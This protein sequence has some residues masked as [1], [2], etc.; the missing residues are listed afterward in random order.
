MENL[1]IG[2]MINPTIGARYDNYREQDFDAADIYKNGQYAVAYTFPEL[3][4]ARLQYIGGFRNQMYVFNDPDSPFFDPEQDDYFVP[5]PIPLPLVAA[6][7]AY[8]GNPLS[9][10][11]AFAYNRIENLTIDAGFTY[12]LRLSDDFVTTR[13]PV[14]ISAAAIYRDSRWS[15]AGRMDFG[16]P[17]WTQVVQS[18]YIQ[19]VID[20]GFTLNFNFTAGYNL[21][22]ATVGT[23][24]AMKYGA[25]NKGIRRYP[26]LILNPDPDPDSESD[27]IYIYDV[28][29]VPESDTS[30]LVLGAGAWIMKQIGNASIKIGLA[31]SFPT[32]NYNEK[33]YDL[34]KLETY[35]I[36]RYAKGP[37]VF[38]I[39]I[40]FGYWL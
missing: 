14:K 23:E 10:Q 7:I 28:I 31:V 33:A 2:T 6:N 36:D 35:D 16:F 1:F 37:W 18:E 29:E 9:F 27:A 40:V 38:T 22:F 3:G 34:T 32:R 11:A 4:T 26:N 19:Y 25:P 12:P 39:P 8:A 21:G 17:G 13:R 5:S 30:R 15:I 24:F 20:N